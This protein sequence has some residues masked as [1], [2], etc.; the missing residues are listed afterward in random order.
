MPNI[1]S[2]QKA[3]SRV[4]ELTST[5]AA[6]FVTYSTAILGMAAIIPGFNLPPELAVLAG[7]I[8]VEAIG[9]L[10]DR[11]S[12]QNTI[13]DEEILNEIHGIIEQSGI[14]KLLTKEDF[15]HAFSHLRKG[16]RNLSAQNQELIKLIKIVEDNLS[17]SKI[18]SLSLKLAQELSKKY[19]FGYALFGVVD[20]SFVYPTSE[21]NEL[22]RRVVVN[23]D[24][25][26]I[27][28]KVGSPETLDF[29]M[30]DLELRN[31]QGGKINIGSLHIADIPLLPKNIVYTL[32]EGFV[33]NGLTVFIEILDYPSERPT[34]VLGFNLQS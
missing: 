9:S 11:V 17:I 15:Y 2:K 6:K 33:I 34:F 5:K 30:K 28:Q 8:G 16:Q 29:V 22:V 23:W 4:L 24:E 25:S 14:E 21:E 27:Q 20:G 10:L 3:L 12:E 32:G 26:F 1:E 31:Q 13:S 18:N 7:G 19:P